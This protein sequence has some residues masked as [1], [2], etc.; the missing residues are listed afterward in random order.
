MPVIC[1]NEECSKTA[2]FGTEWKKPRFC[3]KHKEGGMVDVHHKRC[4]YPDCEKFA[5]Y[6]MKKGDRRFCVKHKGEG[7]IE[8]NYKH[9]LHPDCEKQPYFGLLPKKPTHCADHKSPDMTD[10][11]NK[12]CISEHCDT[13]ITT[14]K[15]DGYCAFCFHNLFPDDPRSTKYKTK[16]RLVAAVFRDNYPCCF[17]LY[18][19]TLPHACASKRRPD[20]LPDRGD[21][22]FIIEIDEDQH[23]GYDSTCEE[24]RVNDLFTDCGSKPMVFIRFN[25]DAYKNSAGITVKSSFIISKTGVVKPTKYFNTRIAELR[26]IVEAHFYEPLTEPVKILNL[27]FDGYEQITQMN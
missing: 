20:I 26:A 8:A 13:I 4:E 16:E 12:R 23:R 10:V 5:S 3:A 15:Y 24:Q 6:G 14:K 21:R 25:P 2:N 18:D 11:K 1:K 19:K 7:M 17:Q 22:V 9:C 27:F